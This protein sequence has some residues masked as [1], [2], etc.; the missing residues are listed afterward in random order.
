[1]PRGSRLI[2]PGHVKVIIGNPII[3]TG[4][5]EKDVLA[6]MEKTR[7]EMKKY[8]DPDYDPFK[9]RFAP[10]ISADSEALR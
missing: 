5:D 2:K 3:T 8:L 6:L 9:W 7:A 10:R 4:L 1:M